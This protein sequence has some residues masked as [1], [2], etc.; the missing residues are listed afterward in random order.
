MA[1]VRTYRFG[2]LVHARKEQDIILDTVMMECKQPVKE[3]D[4]QPTVTKSYRLSRTAATMARHILETSPRL[5][6]ISDL[7][8]VSA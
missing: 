1:L 3:E 4:G 7:R 2:R 5:H 8:L 6:S